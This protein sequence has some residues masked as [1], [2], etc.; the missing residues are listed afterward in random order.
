MQVICRSRY[1][2]PAESH[3]HVLRFILNNLNF[4]TRNELNR[5]PKV[6]SSV[7]TAFA[8]KLFYHRQAIQKTVER[9]VIYSDKVEGRNAPLVTSRLASLLAQRRRRRQ[10]VVL[11]RV[12][13]AVRVLPSAPGGQRR[14]VSG[15]DARFVT[16]NEKT[17]KS[18][19]LPLS[20][21]FQAALEKISGI[22]SFS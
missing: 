13:T 2:E 9:V 17:T 12:A 10:I 3:S 21:S 15:H 18:V 8:G 11:R 19:G 5:E 20:S 1:L 4:T 22:F 14:S 16:L 7:S 6:E